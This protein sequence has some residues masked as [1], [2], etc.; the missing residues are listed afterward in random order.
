VNVCVICVIVR[1]KLC[2]L[3]AGQKYCLSHNSREKEYY[4]SQTKREKVCNSN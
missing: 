1:E 4:V 2:L 3:C